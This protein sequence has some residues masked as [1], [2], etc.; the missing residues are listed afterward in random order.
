M[1][2]TL[3]LMPWSTMFPLGITSAM[4]GIAEGALAA[5]LDYQR[6]RVG[7]NGVAIKDD[8][9]VMYAIGEAAADI[10]AARQ[11]LLA[12]VDRDLRHRRRRQ[13]GVTSRTVPP[14]AAPRCARRGAR[15]SAVDEIFARSGGNALRMDKP[16]QRYWRDAHAGLAHA[17]HVPGTRL[18]RVGAEL[19][20]CRPAGSAAGDDLRTPSMSDPARASATSRLQA[21]DIDAMAPVRL[22]RAGI[23]RRHR[24]R[25]RRPCTCGWT[26]ARRASSSCPATSTRSSRSAGR[27]ATTPHCERVKAALDA[28]G[29]PFKELTLAEA[30]E[31][32]VEEVIA[33]D[34]PAGTATGGVPRRGAR[35]QPGGDPV[36]R[37][38]RHRRAGP[39]PRGAACTGC[40]GLFE[41]YTEVLGFRL[42][43]RVPGAGA[44]GIRSAARA[45]PGHQR[46]SPQPGDLPGDEPAR[47]RA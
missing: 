30:D 25:R 29:V 40:A 21:T 31:R 44:A 17:I 41:F 46:A 37:A 42:A 27:S 36:R 28:A 11:E 12:N 23:R 6:E 16:L 32:R 7:A 47:A 39:G 2:E 26:S 18:P 43:R 19:A 15:S 22:R 24:S 45:V 4:I 9:Y 14:V 34:D 10:N 8:P 5:H 35:P 33:F 1:T 20:R 3:Y 13:G 38:V